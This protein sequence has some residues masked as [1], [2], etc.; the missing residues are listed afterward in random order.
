LAVGKQQTRLVVC[1]VGALGLMLV[2]ALVM[3][4]FVIDLGT[5]LGDSLHFGLRTIHTCAGRGVCV[6]IPMSSLKG[7]YGS[8]AVATFWST[9]VFALAV[10]YQ[11][12]TK[13]LGGVANERLTKWGY[14][15]GVMVVGNAVASAYLFSPEAS[16]VGALPLLTITRTWAPLLMLVGQVLGIATMYYAVNEVEADDVG[17]Y[18]RVVIPPTTPATPT[19]SPTAAPATAAAP[20]AAP[21]VARTITPPRA[22]WKL[23]RE[24]LRGKLSYAATT[25][26]LK[27]TGID[28]RRDD[29][30]ARLVPW[31]EVV[32]V[33]ARR[34]PAAAP[35]E[36]VTFVDVVSTAG[37][38]LRILP[39]THII[40]DLPDVDGDE[41][42]RAFV[43][44]VAA[45]CADLHLDAATRTFLGSHGPAAQLPDEATLA[46][47][48][49][50][51]A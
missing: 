46:A 14:L 8:T 50:R 30:L 22:S 16:D 36:S 15:L 31:S 21:A 11:A 5:G 18:K 24:A 29:G 38:T 6:T 41:R 47:H 27:T 39:W 19:T 34:L 10:A 45:R 51:L 37:A 13:L 42:A 35:Y 33:V 32:G 1:A 26:E 43:Q 28:A 44:L 49:A 23:A 20:V 12:G 17:T 25:V 2:T 40:G 48:D 7:F 9:L 3:D 4:W